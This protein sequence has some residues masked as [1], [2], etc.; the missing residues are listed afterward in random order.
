MAHRR[1]YHSDSVRRS[2][3]DYRQSAWY[4][5]TIC[6]DRRLPYFGEVRN[7]IMGLSPTGCVALRYWENIAELNERAVLDA[8]IVMPNHIHGL[9]GLVPKPNVNDSQEVGSLESNDPTSKTNGSTTSESTN[10]ETSAHMSRISPDA[11]SVSAIVRSYKTAVT[12]RVRG[13]LRTDFGWQSR[14]HDHIVRTRQAF[15]NIRQYIQSNPARWLQDQFHPSK[16][17]S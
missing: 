1:R 11:G 7:G 10:R 13:T 12:K 5:I 3:W 16:A 6:T 17:E 4:F 2:G 9:L 8:F 14:F 15:D